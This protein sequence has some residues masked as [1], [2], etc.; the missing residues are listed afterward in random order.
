MRLVVPL[1]LLALPLAAQN[2]GRHAR[3]EGR[4]PAGALP[5]IDSLVARA[6]AESLPTEPLVQKA[7]EGGAK[8]ISTSRIVN[9]VRRALLQLENAR[10]LLT[11]AAPDQPAG[12]TALY[13]VAAALGRGLAPGV[14]RQIVVGLPGQPPGPPLHA[15]ADL[16]A[17]RFDPDSAAAL[18]VEAGRRGLQGMRLLDVANAAVHELQRG[19]T[20]A[21]ALARVREAVTRGTLP[22]S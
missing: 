14:V 9:A 19:R 21:E 18:I 11:Q 1:A 4:V 6:V 5:V 12:D 8:R 10:G 7:L 22:G 17:H 13:A 3:L 15:V 2:P 16:V 20:R